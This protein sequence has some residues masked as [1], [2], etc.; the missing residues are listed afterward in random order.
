MDREQEQT[1]NRLRVMY[2]IVR[3]DGIRYHFTDMLNLVG[4]SASPVPGASVLISM[5]SSRHSI[6]LLQTDEWLRI[7]LSTGCCSRPP[8]VCMSY[9]L[10]SEIAVYRISQQLPGLTYVVA[11]H[12]YSDTNRVSQDQTSAFQ[13]QLCR[14]LGA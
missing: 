13:A 4:V 3:R 8:R 7:W 9:S 6:R 1:L 5:T 10:N 11:L 14:G 12:A 2:L